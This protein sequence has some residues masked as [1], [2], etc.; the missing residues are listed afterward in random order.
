MIKS[1]W[2]TSP[3]VL[4]SGFSG[5][6]QKRYRRLGLA[7][8]LVTVAVLAMMAASHIRAREHLR[9]ELQRAQEMMT[10]GRLSAASKSLA[11]LDARWPR[12]GE[13]LLPLGQCERA[14]GQ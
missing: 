10:R 5:N 14:L 4:W 2:R 1:R 12:R 7:T 8:A 11:D 3:G 13:I 6:Q 9:A